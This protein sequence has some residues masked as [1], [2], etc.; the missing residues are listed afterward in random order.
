MSKEVIDLSLKQLKIIETSLF[1][2]ETKNLEE[3]CNLILENKGILFFSGVGK[4][5]H[6]AAKS[7]STFSSIGIKSIFINPVD[8]VHGDM[9]NVGC[10]DIVFC[11]SKSGR[12]KELINFVENLLILEQKPKL[13]LLHSNDVSEFLHY[14]DY[15]ICLN[16]LEEIDNFNIVPTT[17][18]TAYTILLQSIGI[19]ISQKNGFNLKKFKLNHP[20]G[21]IGEQLSKTE[22]NK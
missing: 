20:G 19:L 13:I 11:I 10:N 6:V 7:A 15:K 21:N 3:I 5:G 16:E 2:L 14:F 18:I 1:N 12:T 4:N 9:G 8:A 22:E 17:S